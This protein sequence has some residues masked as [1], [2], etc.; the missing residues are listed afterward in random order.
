MEVYMVI[1]LIILIVLVITG[2][3]WF[4]VSN[5]TN[6]NLQEI[7]DILVK[8]RDIS[9]ITDPLVIRESDVT[10]TCN[11]SIIYL[12]IKD[13]REIVLRRAI[14]EMAHVFNRDTSEHG[15]M[16]QALESRFLKVA[17]ELDISVDGDVDC[18]TMIKVQQENTEEQANQERIRYSLMIDVI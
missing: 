12:N 5:T 18:L 10:Y 1:F 15:S 9:G 13:T 17:K 16:F 14:H 6:P 11:R 2:I 4:F 8:I 3:I 7:T